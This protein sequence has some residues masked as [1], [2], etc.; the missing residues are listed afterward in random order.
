[1]PAPALA[2]DQREPK[3]SPPETAEGVVEALLKDA[4]DVK[5]GLEPTTEGVEEVEDGA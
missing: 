4:L 2:D 1:M 3:A 5:G